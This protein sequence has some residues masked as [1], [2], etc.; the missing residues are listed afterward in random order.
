LAG[1]AAAGRTQGK[2]DLLFER[3]GGWRVVEFKPDR[4]DSLREHE[5]QLAG[6][7]TSMAGVVG[8]EVKAV[9]CL[10]RRGEV[11]ELP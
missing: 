4:L 2:A 3:G 7:S 11:V 9:I 10:V 6:Y 5:E 8:A 1:N